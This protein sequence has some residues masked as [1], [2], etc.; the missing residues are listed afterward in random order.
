MTYILQPNGMEVTQWAPKT[1]FSLGEMIE[2]PVT[3]GVF[4][5]KQGL[6]YTLQIPTQDGNF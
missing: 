3:V 4:Q 2:V 5:G 1:Y 6:R